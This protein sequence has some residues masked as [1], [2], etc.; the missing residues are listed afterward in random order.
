MFDRAANMSS[1]TL[2]SY[3]YHC[4]GQIKNTEEL[5]TPSFVVTNKHTTEA[6]AEFRKAGCVSCV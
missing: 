2:E 1:A 3:F 5:L 6:D 4:P